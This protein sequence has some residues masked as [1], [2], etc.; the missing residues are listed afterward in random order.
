MMGLLHGLHADGCDGQEF[1]T[2]RPVTP[3]IAGTPN[4]E[5]KVVYMSWCGDC[6]AA[7]YEVV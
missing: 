4:T 1:S 2:C 5:I 6:G 7:D 3:D